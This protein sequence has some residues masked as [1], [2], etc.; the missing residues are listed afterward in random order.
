MSLSCF[1]GDDYDWF[2]KVEEEERIAVTG[3]KCYGCCKRKP[4]GEHVRRVEKYHFEYDEDDFYYGEGEEVVDGYERLCEECSGL[5]DS[6][7]ELGFCLT[8]DWGFI[9]DAMRDYRELY[10]QI[11]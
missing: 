5:H 3:F 9:R 8:A 2:F 11:G 7:V 10:T 6:L 4:A 1:C